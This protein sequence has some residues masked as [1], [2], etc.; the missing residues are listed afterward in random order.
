MSAIPGVSHARQLVRRASAAVRR[1]S[2][3]GLILLYHRV[4]GP[5]R[6]PQALDVSPAH[7]DDHLDA[8]ARTDYTTF[9]YNYKFGQEALAGMQ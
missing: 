6:D 4:A 9:Q 1:R 7:F 3:R 8:L 2:P 5:R